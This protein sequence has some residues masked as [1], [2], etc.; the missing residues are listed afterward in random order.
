MADSL[1]LMLAGLAGVAWSVWTAWP[2]GLAGGGVRAGEAR[3]PAA[4]VNPARIAQAGGQSVRAAAPAPAEP[5]PSATPQPDLHFARGLLENGQLS[6]GL[7]LLPGAEFNR[8]QPILLSF[9]PGEECAYGTGRACV[10][11]HRGGQVILLTIHSGLGGQ[12]EQLRHALE[13]SG[14]DQAGLTIGEIRA[15]LA[16][17]QG[18]GAQMNLGGEE[19]DGL[20]LA[21]VVRVPAMDLKRYFDLAVDD[22]L[23]M[24]AADNDALR[25]A[26]DSGEA[27][28]MFEICGWHLPGEIWAPGSSP[29]TASIYLGVVRQRRD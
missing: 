6:A 11:R 8:G 3:T 15:N 28:L 23:E 14:L 2:G 17:L 24:L 27:L 1:A 16:A 7:R 12:G 25:A 4:Q 5:A 18:A 20:E 13:G 22:A 26:L 21:A 9:L 10:S 19:L 29:T